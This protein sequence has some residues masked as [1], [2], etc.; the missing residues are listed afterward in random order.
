MNKKNQR[1]C[2]AERAW[3]LDNIFR[4]IIHNPKKIMGGYVKEGMV[5]LDVGCGPGL[6]SVEMAKMV[7]KYGKVIAVDL[8]E[9]MLRKLRKK[10]RGKEIEQ[11]IKLHKCEADRI[12]ISEKADFVL[13]FYMVHEVPDQEKLFKEIK[14]ILKPRGK[15]LIIEPSFHVSKQEFKK[16]IE[17][18]KETGFKPFKK[19][20]VFLS[21]AMLMEI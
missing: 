16:T 8:Q 10:I 1:V 2:P 4:K 15:I 14:S 19:L 18:A 13:L 3:G 20:K 6:F 5:A 11:R 21:R 7:G 12:G 17:S 9:E